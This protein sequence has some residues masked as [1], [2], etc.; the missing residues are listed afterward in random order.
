MTEALALLTLKFEF[1]CVISCDGTE[2][3]FCEVL[4]GVYSIASA[5]PNSSGLRLPLRSY[6]ICDEVLDC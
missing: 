5:D 4:L 2:L 3:L 1:V 6:L